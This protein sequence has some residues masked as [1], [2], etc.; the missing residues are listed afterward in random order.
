MNNEEKTRKVN[1]IKGFSTISVNEICKK[2]NIDRSNVVNGKTSYENI[3]KVY[4]M[5][6]L[7]ITDMINKVVDK[8]E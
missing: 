5:L 7:E 6:I 8:N 4:D 1:F 2:L 3:S